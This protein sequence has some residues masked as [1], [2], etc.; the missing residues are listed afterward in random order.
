MDWVQEQLWE[1]PGW[2]AVKWH[3]GRTCS[4]GWNS[5]GK[6]L[7]LP[8]A[9]D[10]LTPLFPPPSIYFYSSVSKES[11]LAPALHSS[12]SL[13][14]RF[15]ANRDPV[16]LKTGSGPQIFPLSLPLAGCTRLGVTVLRLC[17]PCSHWRGGGGRSEGWRPNP[18]FRSA[19]TALLPDRI[20]PLF[21]RCVNNVGR[22]R[23]GGD[24]HLPLCVPQGCGAM[25]GHV[26]MPWLHPRESSLPPRSGR[27]AWTSAPLP[28]P[29]HR[30]LGA[31][32][33]PALPAASHGK[34]KADAAHPPPPP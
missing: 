30:L 14:Q 8:E 3:A 9:A 27:S 24:L 34:R 12:P 10:A 11:C 15:Q 32:G 20:Q 16:C 5:L 22:D 29:A 17:Q 25:H 1:T 21:T 2:K 13:A 4:A 31:K 6:H 7:P 23:R 18:A 28:A 33:H 19:H 26:R